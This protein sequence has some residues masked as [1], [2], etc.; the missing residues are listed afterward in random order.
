MGAGTPEPAK[1]TSHTVRN[2]EGW[3]VE[4]DDRLLEQNQEL[5]DLALRLLSNQLFQIAFHLPESKVEKL[6]TIKIRLDMT[7]GKLVSPQYHPSRSWLRQNGYSESLAKCV[8]I[9]N[10][11]YYT[12]KQIHRIQPWFMLH[13]LAHAWHDQFLENGFENAPIKVAWQK[14][15]DSEKYVKTLHIDGYKTKHYALT[16]HKEFFAEFTEAF[17]GVNDFFPFNRAE[18][19]ND[20]PEIE[21]LLRTIWL[22][23]E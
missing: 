18:L 4:I 17:F 22:A 23:G 7:H 19:K 14:L 20:A 3:T 10:A 21:E 16:D 8:H 13:E 11:V 9:P 15:I 12:S 2:M 1:P 6:R 5:G